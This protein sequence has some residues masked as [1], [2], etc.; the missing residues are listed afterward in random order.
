M[1]YNIED[2]R[3]FIGKK[4]IGSLKLSSFKDIS[5]MLGRISFNFP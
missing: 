5:K 4:T 1:P 3:V 2:P